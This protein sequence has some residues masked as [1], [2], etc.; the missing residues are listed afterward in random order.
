MAEM[1]VAE[2][3]DTMP[4]I[5]NKAIRTIPM[6]GILLT[7]NNNLHHKTVR[8]HRHK[9]CPI[10]TKVV[11]LIRVAEHNQ[12]LSFVDANFYGTTDVIIYKLVDS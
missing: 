2:D 8:T 9:L 5:S 4:K 10:K 6:D 12:V 7:N 3:E 11:P 1:V